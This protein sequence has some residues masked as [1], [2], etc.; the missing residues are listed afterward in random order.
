VKEIEVRRDGKWGQR[1][2]KDRAAVGNVMDSFMDRAEKELSAALPIKGGNG[3]KAPDFS[4]AVDPEKHESALRYIKLVTGCRSF[5]AAGSFAAKQKD[6]QD[7]CVGYLRRYNEDLVKELRT[8]DGPR[9]A[10]VEQQ[11]TLAATLTALLFSE[12]E[13]ELLRRRARAAQSAAA[14]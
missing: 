3:P 2:L 7:A 14:A 10:I 11:F 9:R 8:A 13:A 12:E 5:A 4:K 6:A 1:L